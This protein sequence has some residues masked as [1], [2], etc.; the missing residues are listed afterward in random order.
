M[1]EVTVQT[2]SERQIDKLRRKEVKKNRRG[3]EYGAESSLPV[4]SFASL[5]EASEKKSPF[6]DLIGTGQEL[7]VRDLP[8]GTIRK[9]FK[10]YEEVSIP[11]T[12]TAEMRSDEKLV[13]LPFF[14]QSVPLSGEITS[15]L[16][17]GRQRT[18]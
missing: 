11:P 5:L 9:H 13:F 10:G 12:P 16:V 3:G 17:K 1:L 14:V 6:D 18:Q 15:A 4:A 2:E 7:P 8:Q